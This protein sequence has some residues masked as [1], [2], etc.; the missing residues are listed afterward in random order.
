MTHTGGHRP[1]A[2]GRVEKRIAHTYSARGLLETA[3]GGYKYYEALWGAAILHA[4]FC[5]NAAPFSDGRPSP[6]KQRTGTDCDFASQHI[7]GAKA[8]AWM[9]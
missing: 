4:N 2:N 7:F 1:E 3:T 8:T 6:Y 9:D 5:V